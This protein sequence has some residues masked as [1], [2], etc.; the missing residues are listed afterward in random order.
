M[1]PSNDPDKIL[2]RLEF[3]E[4]YGGVPKDRPAPKIDT[5]YVSA[6]FRGLIPLAEKWG[7][8]ELGWQ[9]LDVLEDMP[10]EEL[11]HLVQ[12]LSAYISFEYDKFDDWLA[13]PESKGSEFST[14]YLAFTELRIVFENAVWI[15][16][17]LDEDT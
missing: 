6:E 9:P 1:Y 16:D 5:E 12:P 11:Q 10:I 14:A 7:I 13:G 3:R 8:K 2:S 15:L 17:H 4:K